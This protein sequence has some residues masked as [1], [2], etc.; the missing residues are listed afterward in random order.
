MDIFATFRQK[1]VACLKSL[2]AQQYLPKDSDFSRVHVEPP[3]DASHGE[4]ST[5]AAM[6][7]AKNAA[8]KP[9]D[10]AKLIQKEL[11]QDDNIETCSIAGSGFINFN[12]EPNI[13]RSQI[14]TVLEQGCAYGNSKL[15]HDDTGTPIKVNV[16]YVSA[17]PTGPMH[18]GH[19]RG[20]VVGDALARLLERA[21]FDV[22]REYYINDAGSQ[23]ETLA[24]SVLMRAHEANGTPMGEI[25]KGL[26]PGDYLIPIGKAFI[27]K[28]GGAVFEETEDSQITK[29]KEIALPMI[30]A[31][32][33]DD[34]EAL[35]VRHDLFVSE[36]S[37]RDSGA[38]D[39]TLACLDEMGLIYQ[40]VLEPPKGKP[41]SDWE[42]QV[43]T[44]F[45]STE[46]GD[47]NDR[48]LKKSDG[49]WT[50]F[51]P[52][53]AYHN[54]K[55]RRGF[56]QMIDVW[57]ADHAGYIKRM[58]SAMSAMSDN[59]VR[60]DV[61]ICQIVKLMRAGEPIKMSK[62]SGQ[63]VTL[64]AAVN[65]VGRDVVR[66]MMLTRKN[67]APLDF[68]FATV[69]EKSRENPVF[70]VQYA[71][72]RIYSVC[73]NAVR[74]GIIREADLLP[75]S[76]KTADLS[77]LTHEQEVSLL[78]HLATLPR[79]LESA[80]TFHEPH[81]IFIYLNEL[82]AI[83][84]SLWNMGKEHNELKF[85]QQDSQATKAKMAMICAVAFALESG[86]DV[87]GVKPEKEMR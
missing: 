81:R 10:L 45:K 52:D 61:K 54:D 13:W 27:E 67:D 21:G 57:G 5:N 64:R 46:F 44:L 73:R 6:V 33:R 78:R 72:A 29:A 14:L 43:Q 32:I 85:I 23:I 26:Y 62:R 20:A 56:S 75:E 77:I 11:Q 68:D 82:A 80:A 47:D 19:A 22:T 49:S 1:V 42:S 36:Q 40:G 66:F 28:H 7:L 25:P 79:V 41:P 31:M 15:G 63:F 17:N 58:Q 69:K 60:L 34:L 35:G 87:L 55:F 3:R 53:I 24:R 83:F 37:L 70:Y 9:H 8:M 74:N 84:H 51:A 4:M 2:Q 50:Y 65:E 48:A 16:E 59:Q 71:Y 38:V 86:L 76:L 12:L 39:A 18:V 30:M